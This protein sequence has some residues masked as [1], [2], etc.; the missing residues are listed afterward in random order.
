MEFL[1]EIDTIMELALSESEGTFVISIYLF[2]RF[3]VLT[4]SMILCL[5]KL[6]VDDPTFST[7][8]IL[9]I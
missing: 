1:K 3:S 2:E 9:T 6:N 7:N 5:C 4:L 8:A